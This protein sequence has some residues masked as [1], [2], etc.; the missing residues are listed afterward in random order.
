MH[1]HIGISLC[2]RDRVVIGSE[3]RQT[4]TTCNIVIQVD[5]S[6]EHMSVNGKIFFLIMVEDTLLL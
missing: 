3:T 5:V 2:D 4:D 6:T 1:L